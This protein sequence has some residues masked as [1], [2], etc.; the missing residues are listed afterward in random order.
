[1]N[2]IIISIYKY[3]QQLSIAIIPVVIAWYLNKYLSVYIITS[4]VK[5]KQL[6]N[7]TI[8]CDII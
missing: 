6:Y 2:Q 1:M 8:K 4:T 3:L 7:T 5:N